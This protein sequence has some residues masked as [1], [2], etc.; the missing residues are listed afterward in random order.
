[1][2]KVATILRSTKLPMRWSW[3]GLK[4]GLGTACLVAVACLG[5]PAIADPRVA[6]QVKTDLGARALIQTATGEWLAAGSQAFE[7]EKSDGRFAIRLDSASLSSQ[8]RIVVLDAAL[9]PTRTLL[10]ADS[11]GALSLSGDGKRLHVLMNKGIETLDASSGQR[12]ARLEGDYQ[13]AVFSPDGRTVLARKTKG[14][15]VDWIDLGA[16]KVEKTFELPRDEGEFATNGRNVLFTF[17]SAGKVVAHD[18]LTGA[19]R[20]LF[21]SHAAAV[22][23]AQMSPDGSMLAVGTNKGEIVL[24]PLAGGR[25][26]TLPKPPDVPIASICWAPDSRA[27]AWVSARGVLAA[28]HLG[29]GDA[30]VKADGELGVMMRCQWSARYDALVVSEV[31]GKFK[32]IELPGWRQGATK[33]DPDT[34]GD[35][36]APF[37]VYGSNAPSSARVSATGRP[38]LP[39]ADSSSAPSQS[40]L[41]AV[42]PVLMKENCVAIDERTPAVPGKWAIHGFWQDNLIAIPALGESRDRMAI[43]MTIS[44]ERQGCGQ[45]SLRRGNLPTIGNQ[46]TGQTCEPL[47]IAT[48]ET[49]GARGLHAVGAAAGAEAW[50][51]GTRR[52]EESRLTLSRTEIGSKGSK[53][54]QSSTFSLPVKALQGQTPIPGLAARLEGD[55]GLFITFKDR[56]KAEVALVLGCRLE[57]VAKVSR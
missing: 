44:A 7:V 35:A 51:S 49:E 27:L 24:L 36:V 31:D 53:P 46:R 54:G 28:R 33:R 34:G 30:E 47:F 43:W 18:L 39:A 2:R 42:D 41:V 6:S 29:S 25:L 10:S 56:L 9:K 22:S 17:L 50:M 26:I 45:V 55:N 13:S 8:D 20:P 5:E 12:I 1:M 40:G 37:A 38:P 16:G 14:R 48:A 21:A 32:Q 11:I 3:G 4:V 57:D 52:G 23:Q 19:D 15:Q